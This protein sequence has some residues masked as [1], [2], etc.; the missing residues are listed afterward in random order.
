MTRIEQ[1][2]GDYLRARKQTVVAV[3]SC[4]GG[5]I[6]HRLTNIPGSS[7]Y[8]LGGFVTYSNDAKMKFAAVAEET[9]RQYGAVSEPTAREMARGVRAAF[10]ADWALSATG[11]VGPGGGTPTKPVGLVFIGL[12]GPGIDRVQQFL[13]DADREANKQHTAD[14]ALSMLLSA[15]EAAS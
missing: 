3:E 5:L 4:T 13:W 14:A 15:L 1:R 12:C 2:V 11:I 9:L 8:V 7:E 10:G 6:M